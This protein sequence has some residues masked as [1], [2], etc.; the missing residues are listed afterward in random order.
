MAFL[1]QFVVADSDAFMNM[2]LLGVLFVL[3]SLP[4]LFSVVIFSAKF[5]NALTKNTGVS[6]SI[7]K[8]TGIILI[9]LGIRLGLVE[10]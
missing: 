2:V 7:G 5:G 9:G 3:L 10:N 4:I 1:P 8:I 6:Q